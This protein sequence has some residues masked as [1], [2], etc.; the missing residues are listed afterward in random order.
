MRALLLLPLLL[1]ACIGNASGKPVEEMLAGHSVIYG[2][3][4]ETRDTAMWQ[5]WGKDGTTRT[6][7]PSFLQSKSGRWKMDKGTYCEIFGVSTEWTCWRITVSDGGKRI[8]FWQIPGDIGDML[9]F[10]RDM[11]ASFER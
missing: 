6:G 10:H 4:G 2:D 5:E 7:G 1:A 11:D 8:R 3:P 9:F